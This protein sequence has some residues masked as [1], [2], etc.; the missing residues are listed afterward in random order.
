MK[1][2]KNIGVL[3]TAIASVL[4]AGNPVSCPG[5][6]YPLTVHNIAELEI[7]NTSGLSSTNA[8][9]VQGYYIA[10]DRG[11]GMFR[12]HSGSTGTPDGGRFL[13][14]SNS[15]S[16]SGRWERILHGEVANVKMWG[17]KG[18][19]VNLSPTWV[20]GATD[21]Y[22]AIQN[23]LNS[24]N[25]TGPDGL[26]WT[27]EI[28]FPAGWYKV[29]N[30]L[31][32]HGGLMRL[33]GE[34]ARMCVLVM[35]LGIQRDILR[36]EVANTAITNN[37]CSGLFDDYI[38]IEDL[39]F[40]F[41]TASG[42]YSSECDHN[43]N[44]AAI[45]ICNPD[46]GTTIRNVST[47]GGGYGIRCFGGGQGAPAAF[48]DVV[49]SDA[50][51]AG[52]SVEACPGSDR[53]LGHVIIDG[54]TGDHRY[55]ESRD[56]AC[57]VRLWNFVGEASIDGVDAEGLYGGGVILHK[58]PESSSGWNWASPMGLLSIRNANGSFGTSF[59]GYT[60][61]NDFLVL[62][63]GQRTA[64]ATLENINLADAGLIRDQVTGR[65]ITPY[66]ATASGLLQGVC[67]IPASYEA[68]NDGGG[69]VRSRFVVGTKL[70]YSFAPTNTGWYRLMSAP[71]TGARIGGRISITSLN[72]SSEFI[73]DVLAFGGATAGQIIVSRPIR[74]NG[75]AFPPCVTEAR[76]G[77]YS[78]TNSVDYPFVD[79]HI[80]NIISNTPP[81]SLVTF[82]YD[83][84]DTYGL[85]ACVGATPLLTPTT[86]LPS[87][88]PLPAHCTL[89][90]CVTNSLTR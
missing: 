2:M 56:S 25:T 29:T 60:T 41:A 24:C 12:W 89:L 84:I 64:S 13:C 71:C 34:T 35:P 28:L 15:L 44:N 39:D 27:A 9:F 17:A 19:I 30:T 11:G 67:R 58:F 54:V 40:N 36:S 72:E 83:L 16:G 26:A 43:T 21:D 14:S 48:R 90:Q 74:D 59:S 5:Q 6:D 77:V 51:I 88:D 4:L 81:T 57:L 78:D 37:S 1:S 76:A 86:P 87:G 70:L 79:V 32:M 85:N 53:A 62:T 68:F 31:I 23:A 63:G 52:I 66:D 61:T 3:A 65:N 55:D 10:G 82:S 69:Y 42:N 80:A 47:G 33:R 73:P 8:V 18:D 46:E 7:I 75:W 50:A 49:C 20:S 22:I 45:V 38:R